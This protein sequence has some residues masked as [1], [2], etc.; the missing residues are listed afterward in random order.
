MLDIL[1][2]KITEVD[3]QH[4]TFPNFVLKI[5]FERGEVGTCCMCCLCQVQMKWEVLC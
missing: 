3:R 1:P 2:Q 5:V 4:S